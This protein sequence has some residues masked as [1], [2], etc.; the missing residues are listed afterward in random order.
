MFSSDLVR[1]GYYDYRL[2]ALSVLISILGTY[3]ERDLSERVRETRRL[4]WL[5]WLFSDAT[6]NGIGAG[7]LQYTE[8]PACNL[9]L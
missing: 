6:A 7:C 9:L 1:V 4:V 3:A 5:L 8:M 2:V